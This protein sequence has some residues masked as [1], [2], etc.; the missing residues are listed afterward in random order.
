MRETAQLSTQKYELKSHTR[1]SNTPPQPNEAN[2]RECTQEETEEGGKKTTHAN[3]SVNTLAVKPSVPAVTIICTHG[4]VSA[5]TL[6]Q[7]CSLLICH[8]PAQHILT[9]T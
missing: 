1:H 9:D 3:S 2:E 5:D 7:A 8:T 4:H 6:T